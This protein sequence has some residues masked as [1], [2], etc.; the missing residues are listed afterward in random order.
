MQFFKKCTLLLLFHKYYSIVLKTAIL[1]TDLTESKSR[2]F[3]IIHIFSFYNYVGE[4]N[5]EKCVEACDVGQ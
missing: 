3:F 1:L 2:H 5:D 4:R